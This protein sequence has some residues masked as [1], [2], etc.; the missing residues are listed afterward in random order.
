MSET[1]PIY[2][3]G[4]G[5]RSVEELIATLKHYEIAYLIDVRTA[6]YSR[7]KPEYSKEALAA[8]LQAQGIRYLFL[9]EALGGR[10]T[11]PACYID[12]K[13]DYELV[14]EQ[15]FYHAGLERVQNAF[16]QQLHVVLMCSE[17][18]PTQCHRSK[19]IGASLTSLDIP[20]IHIDEQGAPKSQEE[21]NAE[22]T[23]G[24]LSI[25]GGTAIPAR[26]LD[27]APPEGYPFSEAD[28]YPFGDHFYGDDPGE[29][30]ELSAPTREPLV[31]TPI[32][33]NL[34]D[35]LLRH[36]GFQKFR[37]YQRE[38]IES[39]LARRD[40]LTIMSTGAGKSLCYQLPALAF[41]GLT[42]VISPLISLMHDQVTHLDQFG[43][44]AATLN[45]QTD[46]E[47]R[48]DIMRQL[49]RGELKLL[50]LSPERLVLPDT[51]ELL[52]A[53][54]VE[55]LVVDEAHCI[56]QW[57]HDFRPEYREILHVRQALDNVPILALTAT[58]TPEVRAEIRGNLKL[59]DANEFVAPFNR[60]NLFLA[61]Q[62]RHNGTQQVLDFLEEHKG[63]PGIVYCLTR[64]GVDELTATLQQAGVH[65][66]PY[67]AGLDAATRGEN[68]RRFVHDEAVVM[69][70]TIAFGMGIDKPDI[71][72]VL[73]FNL[74]SDPESYYQQIGRAGR[75]G[76]RADCL[77]LHA[78]ADFS[79]IEY[80]IRQSEP[81]RAAQSVAR[82]QHMKDWVKEFT[83]RRKWLLKYLG[84]DDAP[85]NCGMCDACVIEEGATVAGS[86]DLTPYAMLFFNCV[87][88]VRQKFGRDHVIGILRGS[89]AK[90]LLNWKHDQLS[91]YNQGNALSNNAWKEI[92]SQFFQLG[93]VTTDDV[94]AIKLTDRGQAVLDGAKNGATGGE[95]VWGSLGSHRRSQTRASAAPLDAGDAALFEKLR[96]LR[97]ELAD[98]RDVPS[99]M[100]FSD[101]SLRDM[102]TRLPQDAA[103]F[104][105]MHGVGEYKAAAFGEA[106]LEAIRAHVDQNPTNTA[107]APTL[108]VGR[109]NASKMTALERRATAIAGL[110]AGRS[111]DEM[112]DECGVQPA[113]VLRYIHRYYKEHGALPEGIVLPEIQVTD[114]LR[115]EV[116]HH[117]DALG[118]DELGPIYWAMDQRVEYFELDLLRLA[119]VQRVTM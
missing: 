48:N 25:F 99:F 11:D 12:G 111:L 27:D 19:L 36:F 38:I 96:T 109:P 81:A 106:F 6:P 63:Q 22:I 78:P 39:V 58:A 9:G 74:A 79:T 93:M 87:T 103:A 13:V 70:A 68:Q 90:R 32:N 50:Y 104:I 51:I 44:P 100:I 49:H 73:H 88:Q 97:R 60:P 14:K 65:A 94:G 46:N 92:I 21:V 26:P 4:Y 18:K 28:G 45:S 52:C 115:E 55:C 24:Q 56:A 64:K 108:S 117:F 119:Y 2:T 113:T 82:L 105:T 20:V 43:I 91:T 86:D 107:T 17:G 15:P 5:S 72:F 75:D 7:Y 1:I 69:V 116:F 42:V 29:S 84:E 37:P 118:M 31:R 59:Q 85:D 57:G 54:Q 16:R 47:A 3:I 34:P 95:K 98:A 66:L 61:V 114:D 89:K 30:E 62:P 112:A 10:P 41:P 80:M 102:A 101:R 33:A 53:A 71:R 110:Q 67:H 77:L 23:N 76:D 35:L 40:T 8:A 83:C